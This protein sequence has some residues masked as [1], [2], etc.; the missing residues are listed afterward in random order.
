MVEKEHKINYREKLPC[1][2]HHTH[3]SISTVDETRRVGSNL[4]DAKLNYCKNILIDEK[5]RKA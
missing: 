5:Q 4:K 1:R 3:D 2:K